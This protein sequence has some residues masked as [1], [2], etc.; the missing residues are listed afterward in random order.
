MTIHFFPHS[1]KDVAQAGATVALTQRATV[2]RTYCHEP[3]MVIKCIPTG[4]VNKAPIWKIEAEKVLKATRN[5]D[6]VTCKRCLKYIM[7]DCVK[8][9]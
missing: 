8:S 1:S 6:K 3:A 4:L 2:L 5:P 9:L 7:Q